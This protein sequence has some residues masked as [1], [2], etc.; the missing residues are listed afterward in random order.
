VVDSGFPLVGYLIGTDREE[1]LSVRRRIGPGASVCG[2]AKDIDSARLFR[3][4]QAAQRVVDSI[5][6]PG[7]AVV[8]LYDGGSD[9]WVDWPPEWSIPGCELPCR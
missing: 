8:S 4:Q 5:G 7:V 6:K 9:W 1:F 3:N 2:Y